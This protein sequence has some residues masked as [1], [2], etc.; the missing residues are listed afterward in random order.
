MSDNTATVTGVD[1]EL[2]PISAQDSHSEPIGAPAS[3][4]IVKTGTLDLGGDG[5]ATVGDFIDYTL[6]V[7]NTGSVSLT[8]VTV[9][10]PLTAITCPGGNPISTMAPG[11]SVT[12]VGSYAITQADIDAGV[13]NNTATAEGLD[14][15]SNLV[16]DSDVHSEIIPGPGALVP[17]PCSGDAYIVQDQNAQLTLIDQSVSPFVF[18]PIGGPTGRELN[19]LGF[20]EPD[21]LMYAV[22]L[23]N[24]PNGNLQ[25]V[26]IDATGTVIGLGRPA[27]LPTGPRFDAGDVSVDGSTMYITTVNQALYKVSL[28]AVPSLPPVS[29]V[30]ITGA[31]G[32]VFDWA[33]SPIDGMLYGG[34]STNGQLAILD[35]VTGL[36]TDVALAGFPSGTAYGG[37]WFDANGILFLYR[38]N[39]E[40]YEIDLAGPTILSVQI[41]PGSTRNDGAA[42]A[43][44]AL[45]GID[46]LLGAIPPKTSAAG[47][48]TILGGQPSFPKAN[49]PTQAD[50]GDVINYTFE[51]TNTGNVPLTNI[52]INDPIVAPIVC[53]SGNPIPV[54]NP[55]ESET[56]TGV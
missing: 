19:N 46:D 26:Q 36:R 22:E 48:S 56:C 37:A 45:N 14:P 17:F 20:R 49:S 47:S 7:T 21:G 34:D 52:V 2:N 50:P 27:G 5:E 12:C 31:R 1:P 6:Q 13:R 51:V 25:I 18:I 24:S 16:D 8:N 23:S 44:A 54:L 39:G 32:N 11:A 43:A 40:I 3:L 10:D 53:P 35:P 29:S 28:S 33:A 55:S 38:N 9:S 4:Q 41:G 30:N 42:C 15:D